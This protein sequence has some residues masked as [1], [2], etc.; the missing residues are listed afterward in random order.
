[1][2]VEPVS[3]LQEGEVLFEYHLRQC[4]QMRTSKSEWASCVL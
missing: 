1:M 2:K 3:A 4:Q